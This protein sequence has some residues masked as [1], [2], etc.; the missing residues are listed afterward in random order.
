MHPFLIFLSFF[1]DFKKRKTKDGKKKT[2]DDAVS[3][4]ESGL[5]DGRF[6]A[7]QFELMFVMYL[8]ED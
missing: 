1:S 6:A 8:C 2:E 3:D 4:S 5:S 7:I